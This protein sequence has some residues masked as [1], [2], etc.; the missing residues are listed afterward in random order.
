MPISDPR[1]GELD[2]ESQ[3]IRDSFAYFGLAVFRA[4]CL[5]RQLVI[6]LAT[7]LNPEFLRT[8]SEERDTY[9]DKHS[10]KTLGELISSLRQAITLPSSL[11]GRLCRALVLRN[12]L[13]HDL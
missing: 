5:E 8:V 3:Q 4:Q 13:A 2:P 10:Q 11:E 1:R 7:S 9:F 6:L 12:W